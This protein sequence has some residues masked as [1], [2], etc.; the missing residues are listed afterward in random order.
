MSKVLPT[1]NVSGG[2]YAKVAERLKAF[3]EE[4][5]NGKID[6]EREALQGGK[7]R[8]V[9][10]IWRNSEE[11]L[12]LARNGVT[13]D[14]IKMT[15]N[16]TASADAIKSGDKE[17]EKLETIAVGRA[18]AM[19]GYLAS[20]EVA[21]RDEMEEFESYKDQRKAEAKVVAIELLESSKSLGEL[22]D[23]FISLGELMADPEVVKVKDEMKGKLNEK[24]SN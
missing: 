19:L 1:I 7:N 13:S 6:S 15:A 11:I 10:R 4:N 5:P 9:A 2:S 16:A 23:H 22:R 18:L 14:V 24:S 17:N 8:F 20:G 3:W 21:S 12:E